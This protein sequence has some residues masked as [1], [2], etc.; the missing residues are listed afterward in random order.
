MEVG[1]R[2][3]GLEGEA[4]DSRLYTEMGGRHVLVAGPFRHSRIHCS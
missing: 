2:S 1:S 3:T 4:A